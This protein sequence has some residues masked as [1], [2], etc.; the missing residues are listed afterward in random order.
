MEFQKVKF[1]DD[2][3]F[4]FESFFALLFL[5]T[6]FCIFNNFLSNKFLS[7]RREYEIKL[8]FYEVL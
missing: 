6:S 5:L 2:W 8:Q 7:M 1:W 4:I 3:L